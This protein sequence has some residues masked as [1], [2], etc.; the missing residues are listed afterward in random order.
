MEREN[1]GRELKKMKMRRLSLFSLS[2]MNNGVCWFDS[3][4][5]DRHDPISLPFQRVHDHLEFRIL[6]NDENAMSMTMGWSA[7]VSYPNGSE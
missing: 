1:V 3:E 2:H 5:A 4:T 6:Q 7:V